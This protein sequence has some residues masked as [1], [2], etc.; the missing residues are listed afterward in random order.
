MFNIKTFKIDFD[1]VRTVKV[2]HIIVKKYIS[3]DEIKRKRINKKHDIILFLILYV[4]TI[5]PCKTLLLQ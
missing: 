1:K 4:Q 5:A 3:L 2:S